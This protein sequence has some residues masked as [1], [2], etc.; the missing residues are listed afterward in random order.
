L[1]SRAIRHLASFA[2]SK[3]KALRMVS[4]E[5]E[6]RTG[7]TRALSATTERE[8]VPAAYTKKVPAAR[9][10]GTFRSLNELADQHG[11]PVQPVGGGVMVVVLKVVDMMTGDASTATVGTATGMVIAGDASAAVA[12]VWMAVVWAGAAVTAAAVI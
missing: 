4:G 9:A 6:G 5:M 1:S 7:E 10:A 2:Y 3:L 8:R 11:L 12:A